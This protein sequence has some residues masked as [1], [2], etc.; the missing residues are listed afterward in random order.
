M[1]LFKCSHCEQ[2][3]YFENTACL[4]CGKTLGFLPQT[5]TLEALDLGD[6]VAGVA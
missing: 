2:V 3:L 4:R 5:L 1:Q 6:A